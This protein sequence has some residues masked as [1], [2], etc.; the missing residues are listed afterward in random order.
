ME[1]ITQSQKHF[2]MKVAAPLMVAHQFYRLFQVNQRESLVALAADAVNKTKPSQD[3]KARMAS[4]E[5][6]VP[7][8]LFLLHNMDCL[9]AVPQDEWPKRLINKSKWGEHSLVMQ[10]LELYLTRGEA[11]EHHALTAMEIKALSAMLAFITFDVAEEIEP[12]LNLA[13]TVENERV[14]KHLFR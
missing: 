13:L 10:G 8:S 12:S 2:E 14:V 1:T 5:P 9:S 6:S 3:L 7:D 4:R 11:L